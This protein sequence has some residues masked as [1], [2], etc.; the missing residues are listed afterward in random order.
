MQI[1]VCTNPRLFYYSKIQVYLFNF[2]VNPSFVSFTSKPNAAS[3]SRILSL[4]AQS[5]LAF[6]CI[7]CSRSMSTTLPKASSRAALFS[8]SA[9]NPKISN[10]KVWN[11]LFNSSRSSALLVAF[12]SI[13]VFMLRI[14]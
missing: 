1:K 3:V 9:F 2:Q 4:V 10:T 8:A 5:L 7:R 6:A 13:T 11:T 12:L 14:A